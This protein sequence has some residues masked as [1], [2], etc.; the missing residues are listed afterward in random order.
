M[1]PSETPPE[2]GPPERQ[3]GGLGGIDPAEL[4][5]RA[6]NTAAPSAGATSWAPPTPEELAALLPQ[7]RIEA[8]LGRGGM[9]AV[10]R[11]VQADLERPVAIKLLPADLAADPQFIARFR[12]E[13]RTLARLQHPGIV[14]VFDS[15]Q[16][17]A[18]HLYFVMEYV[19][20]IDLQRVLAKGGVEPGQA[21]TLIAQIC[22]A[23]HYAHTQGVIHR[24]IKPA[25]ILLTKDGR[26]KV[27]DFGLARPARDPAAAP[28]TGTNVI[29][30]TADYM[31]PE[32][33]RGQADERT[34]IYAL[35][36]M[37]Y[38]LLTGQR[39]HGVFDPPSRKVQID[40]R[41][42]S[43]VLKALQEEPERRYQ[44]ASEMKTDV[45][46]IRTT[47]PPSASK[48]PQA[49]P[50]SSRKIS[51]PVA[52][53]ALALVAVVGIVV[54]KNRGHRGPTTTPPAVANAMSVAPPSPTVEPRSTTAKVK[55]PARPPDSLRPKRIG[56]DSDWKILAAGEHHALVIKADGS[57]WA[58]GRNSYGQL[59]I[60]VLEVRG[61]PVRVGSDTD[62]ASAAGGVQ[63]S[64]AV[65]T[66]GSLWAWGWNE[67]GQLGDGT[68]TDRSSPVRI[69]PERKWKAVCSA[70]WHVLAL[71][72]N[73]SIWASGSNNWFQL[74]DGTS[75]SR[76]NLGR[77][78][79]DNDWVAV[80]AGYGH[81]LALKSDGSLWGWG[82]CEKWGQL[83]V[84]IPENQPRPIRL[85]TDD[86]W[87]AI[88]ARNSL[89][90]AI[91]KN[92]SLWACG[93]N[94]LSQLGAGS[95]ELRLPWTQIANGNDW[96]QVS[97][98]NEEGFALKTDGSLWA[99]G[100]EF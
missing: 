61:S 73:G 74:G 21:L 28:L 38:E 50:V 16:T 83:G 22:D 54:W 31:A 19:D 56:A 95:T 99:W 44:Q 49:A 48:S 60:G 88:D 43:V 47:P 66:D 90:F 96:K 85:G 29:L 62:W 80:A 65:K 17:T 97:T 10:Y 23:L 7:Y 59:G 8:L 69:G 14:A 89:S 79:A 12:R 53:V 52:A 46:R 63:Q 78:G 87:I 24:D 55:S 41:L 100:L 25:N 36:V 3:P 86:D 98:A 77:T 42:D 27:A 2:E 15:G 30:G 51:L 82:Y 94:H 91:K 26:A 35:G 70:P 39:P 68:K 64:F 13:A 93:A 76:P 9:G 37:L 81:S 40:V 71:S 20:G 58:W 67:R 92:H 72:S 1:D 11:G 6:L 4:F 34:D 18:G 57:L 45:D 5:A 75:N 32:Q 84:I 33:R